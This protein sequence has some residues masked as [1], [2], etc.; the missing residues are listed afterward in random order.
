ME[1]GLLDALFKA[2]GVVL[3]VVDESP[4]A[5]CRGSMFGDANVKVTIPFNV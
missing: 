2:V 4:G 5:F 1:V 3:Q